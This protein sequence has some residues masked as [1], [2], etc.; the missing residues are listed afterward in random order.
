[1]GTLGKSSKPLRILVHLDI[2]EWDEWEALR[3]QGHIV[4]TFVEATEVTTYDLI[5]GPTS[6][7]MTHKHRPYLKDAIAAARRQRYPKGDK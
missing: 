3:V 2:A 6:W 4:D 1:M 7:H 5:L